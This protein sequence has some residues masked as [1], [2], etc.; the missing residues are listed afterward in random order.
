MHVMIHWSRHISPDKSPYFSP[1]KGHLYLDTIPFSL[2]IALL[3]FSI[4]FLRFPFGLILH[5]KQSKNGCKT[6]YS[7]PV[8]P[9]T[10]WSIYGID[11]GRNPSVISFDK[12][13]KVSQRNW[14]GRLSKTCFMGKVDK[15]YRHKLVL[16][17]RQLSL[18]LK[19][20]FLALGTRI[21]G[22]MDIRVWNS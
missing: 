8:I 18:I 13:D 6:V 20:N 2:P 5:Q 15:H 7:F 16:G 10:I 9:S 4:I 17:T 3:F 19:E 21:S 14:K 1:R 22:T 12:A 11:E